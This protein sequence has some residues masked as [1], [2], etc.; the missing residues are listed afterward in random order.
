MCQAQ[1]WG[2]NSELNR[3]GLCFQDMSQTVKAARVKKAQS[4]ALCDEDR[5]LL[6]MHSTQTVLQWEAH[7][8]SITYLGV[9]FL[10]IVI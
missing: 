9:S 5:L 4:R 6:S 2:W 10:L 8:P 3:P 1:L 7:H